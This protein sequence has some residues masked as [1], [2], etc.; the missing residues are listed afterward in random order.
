[1]P[2]HY[3]APTNT[4]EH[5]QRK[6]KYLI[7]EYHLRKLIDHPNPQKLAGG[8]LFS[9]LKKKA[10]KV[11]SRFSNNRNNQMR[12]R[13]QP[14]NINNKPR[15]KTYDDEYQDCLKA[16]HPAG[17]EHDP[18]DWCGQYPGDPNRGCGRRC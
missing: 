2:N 15:R 13:Q 6:R 7:S 3:Y 18:R 17:E 16:G 4:P 1:M 14:R 9:W 11:V 10:K 8:G 5:V 12:Q